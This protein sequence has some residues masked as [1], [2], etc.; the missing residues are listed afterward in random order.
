MRSRSSQANTVRED[1]RRLRSTDP[2]RASLSYDARM[3]IAYSVLLSSGLLLACQK[4]NPAFQNDES[5]GAS[6][7]E[8]TIAGDG[9]GDPNSGD[10]DGLPGDGDGKPGDGDGDGDPGDGD[11]Q[12]GDGDG[13]PSPCND[14]ETLCDGT[15]TNL[16]T[17]P[18]NCNE[19][20][21]ECV[22]DLLCS[23]GTC[24][25]KRYVFA[26]DQTFPGAIGGLGGGDGICQLAAQIAQ[27]DG[28]YKAWMSD[29]EQW[30]RETF[31]SSP[32]VYVLREGEVV[33]FSFEQLVS[34]SLV[35]PIN[36]TEF[37]ELI[38]PTPACNGAVEFGVW[39]G[40]NAAGQQELPDC[41]G[42][43]L[44]GDVPRGR[45]GD[46]MATDANWSAT[47]CQEPC[48]V[49]LRIYCVAQ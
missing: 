12:P 17:D 18:M 15:C 30:P 37:G 28:T 1:T 7:D 45:V 24:A 8:D 27:L 38:G 36:R 33:A 21:R 26:T 35:N 47:D 23:N 20:G 29:G 2:E 9:D 16:G 22:D 31:S 49:L 14:G 39:T 4:P 32:G 34:G 40:T 5:D 13:D 42:W 43:M 48:N 44:G 19:C 25:P 6:A 11:G 41:G 10:G 46:A 3:R